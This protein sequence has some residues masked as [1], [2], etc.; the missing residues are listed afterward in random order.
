M[1]IHTS[2]LVLMG[3]EE[4]REDKGNFEVLKVSK[5]KPK[6]RRKYWYIKLKTRAQPG[7][8]EDRWRKETMKRVVK[9]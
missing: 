9:N 3:R 5:E 2:E 1:N 8:G 6:A 7:N 4:D